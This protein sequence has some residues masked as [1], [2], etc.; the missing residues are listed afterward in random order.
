MKSNFAKSFSMTLCAMAI[1]GVML[2]SQSVYA[3]EHDTD[4]MLDEHLDGRFSQRTYKADGVKE[5]APKYIPF[6]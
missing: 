5:S 1:S 6:P 4:V 2:G 3:Y